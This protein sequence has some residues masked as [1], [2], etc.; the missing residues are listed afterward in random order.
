MLAH[1]KE[2]GADPLEHRLRSRARQQRPLNFEGKK[3][4]TSFLPSNWS[5]R[6]FWLSLPTCNYWLIPGMENVRHLRWSSA[7]RLLTPVTRGLLL[8]HLLIQT[9]LWRIEFCLSGLPRG[10][11]EKTERLMG[12]GESDLR[13]QEMGVRE[14]GTICLTCRVYHQRQSSRHS[15]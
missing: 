6:P 1:G 12:K 5:F 7:A 3:K 4:R 10:P 14:L 11:T 2:L 9:W 8:T 15:T 13:E